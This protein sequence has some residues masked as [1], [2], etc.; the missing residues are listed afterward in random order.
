[1]KTIFV[2]D[3]PISFKKLNNL[4]FRK[5]DFDTHIDGSSG[6]VPLKLF[7]RVLIYDSTIDTIAD[8][9]KKMT[10]KKFKKIYSVTVT[11][12]DYKNVLRELKKMFKVIK[13]GGGVV[14]NDD[15]KILFIYRLK[16]WDLPKGKK[17][18]GESIRECA[19]REVE[20]E[21]K[22]KV[23]CFQKIT[24]TW[25]TYTKKKKFILKKTSWFVMKSLDDSKMKPQ[26]KEKIEKVEWMKE[27]VIKEIL[28]NSYRTLNHV[29]DKYSKMKQF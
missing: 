13:A 2:N 12:K 6:I 21:T 18:K 27:G 11:L 19:K 4:K 20:E 1:M 8:L 14:K 22:V 7:S 26:K 17:E 25:H 29:M 3:I 23:E 9:L 5:E 15:G 28:L 16:K 24:S 10:N